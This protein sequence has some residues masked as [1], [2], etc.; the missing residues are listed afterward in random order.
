MSKVYIIR[1]K[2]HDTF[3]DYS[4]TLLGTYSCITKAEK[5]L[6]EFGKAFQSKH[7][8]MVL[9]VNRCW[10]QYLCFENDTHHVGLVID[11]FLINTAVH[12]V[13]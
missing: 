8:D 1:E 12:E 10:E 13:I 2:E 6:Q 7:P 9:Q 3:N 5:A 4:E 11:E